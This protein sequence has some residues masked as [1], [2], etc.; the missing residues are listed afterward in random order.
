MKGALQPLDLARAKRLLLS[1]MTSK[2]ED[3]SGDDED[4]A[5]DEESLLGNQPESSESIEEN[6]N[7]AP[8]QKR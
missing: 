1:E 3:D 2:D 5:V 6:S 4:P 8:S 7:K